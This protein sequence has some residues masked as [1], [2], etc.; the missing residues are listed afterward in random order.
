M[1]KKFKR[2]HP[3]GET[4][5]DIVVHGRDVPV[6][7]VKR[8]KPSKLTEWESAYEGCKPHGRWHLR[9]TG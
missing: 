5:I 1:S 7:A 2:L 8:V 3:L 4:P 6:D 9:R